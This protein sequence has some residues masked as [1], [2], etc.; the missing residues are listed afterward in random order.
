MRLLHRFL[1]AAATG[2]AVLAAGV[3][4]AMVLGGYLVFERTAPPGDSFSH[5][6]VHGNRSS[7]L[8]FPGHR[9]GLPGIA[10]AGEPFPS[11]VIANSQRFF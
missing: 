6:A 3:G 10:S 1:L 9:R 5:L 7:P 8:C 11:G 4:S 2:L